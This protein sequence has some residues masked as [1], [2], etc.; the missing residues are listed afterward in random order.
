MTLGDT[1]SRSTFVIVG[2]GLAGAKVAQTSWDEIVL[3]GDV[4]G[5]RFVASWLRD[6]RV[7]A[8]MNVTQDASPRGRHPRD[9][10]VHACAT[11]RDV[12]GLEQAALALALRE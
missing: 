9:P 4:P 2:A 8:G 11:K 5:R 6:G 7:L 10:H 1:S 3:R 12:L